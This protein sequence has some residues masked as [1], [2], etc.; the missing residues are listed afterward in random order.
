MICLD[1]DDD[2]DVN[3]KND[4]SC[5]QNN[6]Y[7]NKWINTNNNNNNNIGLAANVS[8]DHLYCSPINSTE[9]SPL[10]R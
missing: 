8:K 2:D 9:F 5:V 4:H 7:V 10:Q 3:D 6:I 1:D